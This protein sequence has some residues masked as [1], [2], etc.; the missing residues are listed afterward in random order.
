MCY[1]NIRRQFWIYYNVWTKK[2]TNGALLEK[3]V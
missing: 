2:K 1:L 3:D